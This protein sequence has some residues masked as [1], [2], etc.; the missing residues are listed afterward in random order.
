MD[1]DD[2]RRTRDE[3][4]YGRMAAYFDAL[5]VIAEAAQ[6]ILD[7]Q[8]A[9]DPA[10]WSNRA[11]WEQEYQAHADARERLAKA[12]SDFKDA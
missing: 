11:A 5:V 9:G 8:E 7:H 2:L 1:W 6:G 4:D 10:L 12:L 3:M